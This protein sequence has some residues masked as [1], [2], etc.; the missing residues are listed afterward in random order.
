[1][2]QRKSKSKKH[3]KKKSKKNRNKKSSKKN[4]GAH[5]FFESSSYSDRNTWYEPD[6]EES[7]FHSG[8]ATSDDIDDLLTNLS[9]LTLLESPIDY[10]ISIL[11][12]K[13]PI[14]AVEYVKHF[15]QCFACNKWYLKLGWMVLGEREEVYVEDIRV[16]LSLED[17]LFMNLNLNEKEKVNIPIPKERKTRRSK[18]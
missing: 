17:L 8:G 1:M 4:D 10:S 2:P 5:N 15:G 18:N 9:K 13:F 12:F 7:I 16:E 14:E 11:H 3:K 6:P